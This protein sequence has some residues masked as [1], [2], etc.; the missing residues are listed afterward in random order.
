MENI[1]MIAEVV[2]QS[3]H[4]QVVVGLGVV[5]T[6]LAA[7]LVYLVRTY[8]QAKQAN[9]AVNHVEFGEAR[10][11]DR[12]THIQEVV[13]ELASA[14]AEF[15]AKGWTTLPDEFGD[16]SSLSVY[17]VDLRHG[18]ERIE[19]MLTKHIEDTAG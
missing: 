3:D 7:S 12:I 2:A 6:M 8:G 4:E 18:Q 19:T 13:A 11:F 5:V 10:L 16:A 9:A 17:L 15:Q 1:G 14:N